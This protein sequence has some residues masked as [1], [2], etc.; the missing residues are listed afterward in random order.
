MKNILVLSVL[1]FSFVQSYAQKIRFTDTTNRW[2]ICNVDPFVPPPLRY[3]KVEKISKGAQI[4]GHE[5]HYLSRANWGYQLI[6]EDSAAGKLYCMRQSDTMEV[7]MYD[8][9]LQIGDTLLSYAMNT[10]TPF[11]VTSV[12]NVKINNIDHRIWKFNLPGTLIE[13]VGTT[14]GPRMLEPGHTDMYDPMCCF[15]NNG[16]K[17]VFAANPWGSFNCA[18]SVDDVNKRTGVS[19]SPNPITADSR[20]ILP[21]T[22]K[23]GKLKI[24]NTAGQFVVN[25][26]LKNAREISLR[27]YHLP[28]G[29][30]YFTAKDAETGESFKGKF[31][32][33]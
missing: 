24:I 15:E 18:L 12:S 5:Y 8:Y 17:A 9:N 30:Y 21:Q 33:Q 1:L 25:I 27:E 16:A 22:I 32:I 10:T 4:N 29:F 7:L 31:V 20:I 28:P 13:G 2:Y 23:A 14:F 19:I 26:T 11:I 3:T 6:R